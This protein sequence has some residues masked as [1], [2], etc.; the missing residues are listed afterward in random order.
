MNNSYEVIDIYLYD[1][2][3]HKSTLNTTLFILNQILMTYKDMS[4]C[5][6]QGFMGCVLGENAFVVEWG[7][8]C[9]YDVALS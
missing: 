6:A 4:E 9:V 5:Q 3:I 2:N 8:H 1:Y 7:V